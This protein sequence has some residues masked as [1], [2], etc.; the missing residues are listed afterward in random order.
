MSSSPK[1]ARHNEPGLY[2]VATPIGNLGDLSPRAA[3]VLATADLVAAE[4]T[5]VTAR[6]LQHIGARTP[7]LAH[8][9]HNEEALRP[10]LLARLAAGELVALVSDAGTPLISDPGYRLVRAAREAGVNIVT[11]PG[12]CAAIAALTLAALPTDRFLFAG[13]LP[14]KAGARAAA[15]A[16]LAPVRATLVFYESANRLAASLAALAAG[17]GDRPAAV[18]RELT[19]RFEETL[20]GSLV[21][22]AARI[23]AQPVRG[24]VVIVVGAPPPAAPASAAA[25]DAAL[26]AALAGQPLKSAVAQVAG[27]LGLPRR[28]VYARALELSRRPA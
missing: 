13:F 16:E 18:A 26:A 6:L 12:P 28:A 9:E 19:K 24:E 7:M 25:L 11:V 5:R 20:S 15:I 14:S 22:L 8:H 27:E 10:K 4:D 2:I 17:L 1:P 21:E 23:E 3:E